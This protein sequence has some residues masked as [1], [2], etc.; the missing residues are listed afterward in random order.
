MNIW[1][2]AEGVFTAELVSAEPEKALTAIN[3]VGIPLRRVL[4]T[5]ELTL[6]FQ[7]RRTDLRALQKLCDKRGEQLK[8]IRQGGVFFLFRQ[9]RRRCLLLLGFFIFLCLTFYLPTRV[10]FLRVEGNRAVPSNEIFAAAQA[11]GIHFGASRRDVRSEKV[12][13]ALLDRIPQL[14]WAGINTAGCTAVI[15]VR[16]RTSVV[17]ENVRPPF[18]NMVASRDGYIL[19][20]VVTRGT[21]LVKPG[22][23][24]RAGQTL[25][26]GYTDCGICIQATGAEGEVFAQTRRSLDV[27]TPAN[28][29]SR[30]IQTGTKR[31]FSLLLGKKRI[32]FW[33]DSGISD[34]SCGRMYEEYRLTLPGGFSL[35]VAVCVDIFSCWETDALE[36]SKTDASGALELFARQ[37]LKDQMIAGQIKSS[38]EKI[39][40][41]Q[42]VYSLHGSYVCTEMIGMVKT[43]QIG[44]TNG[45]ANGENRER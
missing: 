21:G 44:D 3:A 6:Q 1:R 37:Y 35:P 30:R 4:R 22:Q 11:C 13:N 23:A 41:N 31:R 27:I 36:I 2:S 5:G 7:L 10:L 19:S 18:S 29:L 45:K 12:K 20:C 25:I 26:S 24:V 34:T 16:E 15:S 38:V 8:I 33:K 40:R 17:P 43:E 9:L 32:F 14:Q 42:G 28:Y 39:T